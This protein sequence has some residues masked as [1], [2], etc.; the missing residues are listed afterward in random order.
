MRTVE[1]CYINKLLSHFKQNSDVMESKIAPIINGK[2]KVSLRT[3]ENFVINYANKN[4][5]SYYK[6]NGELFVVFNNYKA[7]LDSYGK[8]YF[9]TFRRGVVRLFEYNRRVVT[10]ES[11]SE[12]DYIVVY[13]KVETKDGTGTTYD[14]FICK[15]GDLNDTNG[16]FVSV[17]ELCTTK[18]VPLKEATTVTQSLCINT[19]VAQLNY[20]KWLVD[21]D[22]LDYIEK[23]YNEIVQ[24]KRRKRVQK[25]STQ[26]IESVIQSDTHI[27][28]TLCVS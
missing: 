6:S 12:S 9:D 4:G 8:E 13:S 2:S 21:N 22:I 15:Y 5:T 28:V 16:L 3:I 19:T 27:Q 25:E 23:H 26:L 7:Q 24:I 11:L 10:K 18:L 17:P 1:E 20:C 14:S